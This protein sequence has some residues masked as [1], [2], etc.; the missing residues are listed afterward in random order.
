MQGHVGLWWT[1]PHVPQLPLIVT[2]SE[3]YS[4]IYV[5]AIDRSTNNRNNMDNMADS[6]SYIYIYLYIFVYSSGSRYCNTLT[7]TF[8]EFQ[9][10]VR[11][12]RC[13]EIEMEIH[14]IL[15]YLILH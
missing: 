5:G 10:C 1:P 4:E 12:C 3:I 15:D 14:N 9:C 13:I 8:D 11:H 2:D 6:M 7:Y